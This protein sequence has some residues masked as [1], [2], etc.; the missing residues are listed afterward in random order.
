ML[1]LIGP[2]FT[3]SVTDNAEKLVDR[4]QPT[5][6]RQPIRTVTSRRNQSQRH[7]VSPATTST[8]AMVMVIRRD[9]CD[10]SKRNSTLHTQT[11]V[12]TT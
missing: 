5:S 9:I 4:Q 11:K 6:N 1:A 12:Y 10:R 7:K 8:N 3:V 2:L